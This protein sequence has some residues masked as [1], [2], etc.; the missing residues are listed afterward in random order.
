MLLSWLILI[1]PLVLAD[2]PVHCVYT[3]VLGTWSFVLNTDTF[4]ADLHNPE[5]RCGHTQPNSIEM[6]DDVNYSY[7]YTN[8]D[9]IEVVLSEPNTAT[10]PELGTGTWTMIYDEGFEIYFEDRT[11]FTY[12]L[13]ITSDA[14]NK[15]NSV[16]D[17]TFQGWYRPSNPKNHEN[18]GCFHGYRDYVLA[19]GPK[20]ISE[21]ETTGIKWVEP[22]DMH[23]TSFLEIRPMYEHQLALIETINAR[24]S[25]WKAGINENFSGM[26]MA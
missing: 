21:T 3:Q 18:W 13:Y 26:S 5:T 15:W 16:C 2:L 23:L 1:T 11:F 24:Q 19:E 14:E 20:D 12:F 9:T 25:S 22:E 8:L 6:I 7:T 17:K 4:T 10:S